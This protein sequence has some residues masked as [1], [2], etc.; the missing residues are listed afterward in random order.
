VRG[1]IIKPFY[2]IILAACFAAS[3]V[4]CQEWENKLNALQ[5]GPDILRAQAAGGDDEE[6]GQDQEQEEQNYTSRETRTEKGTSQKIYREGSDLRAHYD[7]VN[8]NKDRLGVSFG[9]LVD[10]AVGLLRGRDPR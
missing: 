10:Q 7:F 9:D 4:L 1:T 5:T 3:A 2:L 8:F 6:A